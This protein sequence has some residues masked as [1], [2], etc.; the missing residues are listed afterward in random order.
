MQAKS[1][2]HSNRHALMALLLASLS[3]CDTKSWFESHFP[4]LSARISGVSE[5]QTVSRDAPAQ[6][7]SRM[8]LLREVMLV[9]FM[10]EPKDKAEFM[11]YV[12][13]LAQGASIEG[14]YNGF[15]HSSNYRQLEE[16]SPGSTPDTLRVFGEELALLETELPS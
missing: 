1:V 8:E 4:E 16:G 13:V 12:D 5:S 11:G 2:C 6:S 10:K 15:T 14:I 9:V 3:G 7:R